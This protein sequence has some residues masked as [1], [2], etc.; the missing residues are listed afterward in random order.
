MCTR[1][2]RRFGANGGSHC[3]SVSRSAI[4][5]ARSEETCL[6]ERSTTDYLDHNSSRILEELLVQGMI[7][8]MKIF[9]I[10]LAYDKVDLP[11]QQRAMLSLC[12]VS[13]S[14][15]TFEQPLSCI[16]T[17]AIA[18]VFVLYSVLRIR[19]CALVPH[20]RFSTAGRGTTRSC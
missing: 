6:A 15:Q 7:L 17:L 3:T 14:R 16:P 10:S 20:S 4:L 9:C 1:F 18:R 12:V 11:S 8:I 13:L 2:A 19:V 5:A